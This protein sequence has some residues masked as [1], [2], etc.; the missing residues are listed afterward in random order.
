[1]RITQQ[2]LDLLY[3][4]VKSLYDKGPELLFHGWHHVE[5][6]YRKSSI[7]AKDLGADILLSQSA[8]LVHDLNY[9]TATAIWT[10][11]AAGRELRTYVLRQAGYSAE[12]MAI[13][14]DI[15]ISEE[16]SIRGNK[17]LTPEMKALADADTLFKALPITTPIFSAK[18]MAQTNYSIRRLARKIV[19][20]QTPLLESGSYFYSDLAQKNTS[21]GRRLI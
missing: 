5:F 17:E 20:E 3:T 9:L 2:Q 16:T 11:P 7:F 8:A 21:A 10:P 19:S 13:I 18:F 6:V 12:V 15:V 14:E 1:M 4:T